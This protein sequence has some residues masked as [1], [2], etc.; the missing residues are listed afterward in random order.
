MSKRGRKRSYR[1]MSNKEETEKALKKINTQKKPPKP[2]GLL[3]SIK[4][5]FLS[6]NKTSQRSANASVNEEDEDDMVLDDDGE[7]PEV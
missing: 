4:K 1:D 7:P 2:S 5:N 6:S 3:E